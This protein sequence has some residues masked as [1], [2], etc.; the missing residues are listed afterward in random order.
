M[1]SVAPI[2]L[3][4]SA[5][6][7]DGWPGTFYPADMPPKDFLSF[8]ATRFHTVEVDSTYYRTPTVSTVKG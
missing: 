8:Y 7:A 4:T 5:F 6:T 2:L 1:P 3:G